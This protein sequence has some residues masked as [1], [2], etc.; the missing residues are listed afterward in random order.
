MTA[1]QDNLPERGAWRVV[2]LGSTDIPEAVALFHATVHAVNARDYSPAQLDAWMPADDEHRRR[3]AKK[4]ESQL[5]FG[6]RENGVLVG[7]GSL[8]CEGGELDMLYVSEIRQGLGIACAL[9]AELEQE[10]CT[11]GWR[12]IRTYASLTARPLFES[13]GYS[14]VRE[15]IAVR[16]G[17]E[18]KNF[19]ME[20]PLP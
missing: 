10:A 16:R 5:L 17:V 11:R 14:V 19:L 8:D 12:A 18:L 20:K 3:L 6:V 2:P 9:A 15:N 13:R 7:F 4:L 1:R